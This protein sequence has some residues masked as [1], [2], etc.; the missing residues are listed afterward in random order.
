MISPQQVRAARS[1]IGFH[2]GELAKRAAL[3][4]NT[5]FAYERHGCVSA[6]TKERITSALERL[7]I[8]FIENGVRLRAE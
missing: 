3:S 8:E 5:V 2:Q 1:L 7:G 6:K 4:I